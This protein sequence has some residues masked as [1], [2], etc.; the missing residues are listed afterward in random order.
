MAGD[1][2]PEPWFPK[3][4]EDWTEAFADALALDRSRQEE[5]A[6]KAKAESGKTGKEGETGDSEPRKS[7][8][9]RLLGG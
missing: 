6:A 4:R 5:A 2:D 9:E 1:K 8:A 7:F 3:S